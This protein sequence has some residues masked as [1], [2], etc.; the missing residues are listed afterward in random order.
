MFASNLQTLCLG[1]L[2]VIPALKEEETR[3]KTL[4]QTSLNACI[5][6][7]VAVRPRARAYICR[8]RGARI[9]TGRGFIFRWA[10]SNA[11]PP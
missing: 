9:K 3:S 10:S 1:L 4:P 5:A 11:Q 6:L 8:L 2:Y 7:F